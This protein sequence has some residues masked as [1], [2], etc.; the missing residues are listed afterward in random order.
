MTK[1]LQLQ[2]VVGT[3][4]FRDIAD[5]VSTTTRKQ[6]PDIVIFAQIN[7][8]LNSVEEIVEAI[9]SIRDDI[10]GVGIVWT[11]KEAKLLD[12]LLTALGR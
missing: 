7:P 5:K 1:L 9:N 8:S 12:T 10:D 4:E 6:N 2:K 3:Q 11:S